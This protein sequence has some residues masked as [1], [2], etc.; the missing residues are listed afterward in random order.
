MS[1][2]PRVLCVDDEENILK[3]IKRSLRKHFDITTANSGKEGLEI[4][5][6]EGPFAVI[7]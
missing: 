3:A 1:D 5:R 4:L 7:V 2:L 6:K